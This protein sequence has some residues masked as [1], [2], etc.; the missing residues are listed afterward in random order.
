ML[1]NLDHEFFLDS[2]LEYSAVTVKK[3]EIWANAH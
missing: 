2:L 3:Q 1:Q